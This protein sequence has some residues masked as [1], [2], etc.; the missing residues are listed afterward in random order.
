MYQTHILTPNGHSI[1]RTRFT[2]IS[3]WDIL[4]YMELRE[5]EVEA[6]SDFGLSELQ[7]SAVELPLINNVVALECIVTGLEAYYDELMM[8]ADEYGQPSRSLPA[9]LYTRKDITEMFWAVV[10][11]DD[12]IN[13]EGNG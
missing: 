7:W 2:A 1:P 12:Y 8:D 9:R 13:L 3:L 10:Q 4:D 11:K 5:E 6:I